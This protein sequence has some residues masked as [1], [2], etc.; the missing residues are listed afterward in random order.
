MTDTA[1]K[2]SFGR[3]VLGVAAL[4]MTSRVFGLV[5]DSLLAARYGAGFAFDAWN[6]A[7]L[8][9]NL[10]RRVL[11]EGALSVSMVPVF[12]QVKKRQGDEAA[13]A[14]FRAT[15]G[16][17]LWLL[18]ATLGLFVAVSPWLVA[19]FA[20]GFDA[21]KQALTTELT[22]LNTPFLF[23]IGLSTVAVAA[24]NTFQRFNAAAAQPIIF[25]FGIIFGATVL[26][27][28]VEPSIKGVA[29][30]A[31]V[32]GAA[33]FVMLLVAL[34]RT[35]FGL[36]PTFKVLPEHGQ[37]LR[38]M[39]PG[40]AGVMV[41]YL[42]SMI[43]KT[44]ASYLPEGSISLLYL[45]D[46]L[47]ELPLGVVAVSVATV[48]LPR[49]TELAADHD[50]VTMRQE[51][52]SSTRLSIFVSLPAA[53]GTWAL[54]QS[55]IRVLFTR[56]EFGATQAALLG[57]IFAMAAAGLVASSA[58]R[59]L[60]QAFYGLKRPRTVVEISLVVFVIN[61]GAG[62]LLMGSLGAAGLTLGNSIAMVTQVGLLAFFLDRQLGPVPAGATPTAGTWAALGKMCVAGAV[63]ALPLRALDPWLLQQAAPFGFVGS[64]TVLAAEIAL[65]AALYAGASAALGLTEMTAVVAKLRR[66][67]KR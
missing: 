14:L 52:A 30:G 25:N 5:R 46:R 33:A 31:G 9:P 53:V 22:R 1:K 57:D 66:K 4:T 15:L 12:G 39:G 10:L 50:T 18:I 8:L 26:S 34:R 51:L 44:M 67:L 37:M 58:T 48:S 20:S 36:V 64:A 40:L 16:L 45:S 17:Y 19:L 23:F 35:G 61:A 32:G 43:S 47:V 62:Y 59:V 38:L 65:G 28:Y 42:N 27:L 49:M 21:D 29:L 63:M 55:V 6:V 41:Y 11:A 24:L 3:Q 56:G 13:K 7:F 54:E 2:S 60:V